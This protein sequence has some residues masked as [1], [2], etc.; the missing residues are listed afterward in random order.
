MTRNTG[1]FQCPVCKT[2][3]RTQF[4]ADYCGLREVGKLAF[5][6]GAVVRYTFFS[7]KPVGN[8]LSEEYNRW[9]VIDPSVGLV[10]SGDERHEHLVRVEQIEFKRRQTVRE[11]RNFPESELIAAG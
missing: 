2:P 6:V 7:T 11:L 5:I 3:Y 8:G 10:P 4:E 9:R 1:S